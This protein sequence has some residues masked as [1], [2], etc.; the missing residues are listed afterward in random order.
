MAWA[1]VYTTNTETDALVIEGM[2]LANEIPAQVLSQVDSTRPFGLGGLSIA[3]VYVPSDYAVEA[4]HLI[5]ET[6]SKNNDADEL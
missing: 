2:L 5:A 3:K 1:L 6:L 4:E